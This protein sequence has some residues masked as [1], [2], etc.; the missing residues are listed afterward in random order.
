M[1]LCIFVV[2]LAHFCLGQVKNNA[3]STGTVQQNNGAF[4]EY[5]PTRNGWHSDS[6]LSTPIVVNLRHHRYHGVPDRYY[7]FVNR[8][9]VKQPTGI[10]SKEIP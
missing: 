4:Y 3:S 1:K 5:D 6:S 2:L 9:L 8:T 10:C 7:D